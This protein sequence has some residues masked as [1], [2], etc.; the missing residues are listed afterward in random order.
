MPN[1]TFWGSLVTGC[2]LTVARHWIDERFIQ[3]VDFLRGSVLCEVSGLFSLTMDSLWSVS[4]RLFVGRQCR[5]G[6]V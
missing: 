3:C 1:R 5:I 6:V 2:P 4:G